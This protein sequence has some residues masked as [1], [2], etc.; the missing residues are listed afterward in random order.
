MGSF[1]LSF[2][3]DEPQNLHQ[4]GAVGLRYGVYVRDTPFK[5]LG[6][7]G[8]QP[9]TQ[10][11]GQLVQL[12][13]HQMQHVEVVIDTMHAANEQAPRLAT[14]DLHLGDL[15]GSDVQGQVFPDAGGEAYVY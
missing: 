3:A 7:S 13:G 6:Q 12:H 10:V 9:V 5:R 15:S 8:R 2:L 4:L 1:Q 11:H 14:Y